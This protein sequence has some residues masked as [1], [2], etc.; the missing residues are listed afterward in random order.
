VAL[1]KAELA[2]VGGFAHA[3]KEA[4]YYTASETDY[5]AALRGQ[6]ASSPPSSTSAAGSAP[7]FDASSLA[8]ITHALAASA[9]SIVS[10]DRGAGGAS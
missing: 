1:G 3:L 5:A 6:G 9:L 2:D 8:R 7:F 10:S 4:G